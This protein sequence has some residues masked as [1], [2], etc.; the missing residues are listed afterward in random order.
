MSLR[1]VVAD[2]DFS[3]HPAIRDADANPLPRIE[4]FIAIGIAD[5]NSL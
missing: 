3:F 5:A 2:V 1:T 4:G